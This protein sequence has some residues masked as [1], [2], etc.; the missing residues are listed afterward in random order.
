MKAR[1]LAVSKW[2]FSRERKKQ[3][4]EDTERMNKQLKQENEM[5]KQRN[6]ELMKRISF[7]ESELSKVNSWKKGKNFRALEVKLFFAQDTILKCSAPGSKS[8]SNHKILQKL[9]INNF[10]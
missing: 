1:R 9:E 2:H 6:A 8:F 4:L 7:L 10:L 3:H 5:L